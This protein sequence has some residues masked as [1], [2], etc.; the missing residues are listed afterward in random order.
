LH[1]SLGS[2]RL[3]QHR[4]AGKA[5]KAVSGVVSIKAKA[6][7]SDRPFSEVESFI[8]EGFVVFYSVPRLL[9]SAK[10]KHSSFAPG[11]SLTDGNQ[12]VGSYSGL[13]KFQQGRSSYVGWHAHHVFED[14]DIKRLGLEK[15]FPKY[16]DQLCVLLPPKAHTSRINSILARVSPRDSSALIDEM[17]SDY[18][19]TYS[20]IGNYCGSSEKKIK[21]ELMAIVDAT[22]KANGL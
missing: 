2:L 3:E 12:L 14:N 10:I 11:V 4:C 17:R 9:R 16:K 13:K 18:R 6:D 8:S 20:M 22:L 7:T 15:A 19:A 1:H 21:N 5:E